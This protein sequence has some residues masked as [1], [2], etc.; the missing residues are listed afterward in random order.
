MYG[1]HDFSEAYPTGCVM[2]IWADSSILFL[3]AVYLIRLWT[4]SVASVCS[5]AHQRCKTT[6]TRTSHRYFRG[7][8]AAELLDHYD[9][10]HQTEQARAVMGSRVAV[11]DNLP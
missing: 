9:Q 5:R 6:H 1:S 7:A 4:L 8:L 11:R 10:Q 2:N 3:V